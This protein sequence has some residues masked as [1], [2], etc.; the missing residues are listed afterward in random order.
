MYSITEGFYPILYCSP[1]VTTLGNPFKCHEELLSLQPMFLPK[2]FNNFPP[3][4]GCLEGLDA[5][6]FLLNNSIPKRSFQDMLGYTTYVM[7]WRRTRVLLKV[8]LEWLSRLCHSIKNVSRCCLEKHLDASRSCEHPPV[9]G[10][11]VKTFRWDHR[12]QRPNL[13]MAF[14]QVP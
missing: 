5:F 12:L 3:E 6:R 8:N 9:R 7:G 11:N 10:K 14:K 2:S 1:D 13:P 4:G